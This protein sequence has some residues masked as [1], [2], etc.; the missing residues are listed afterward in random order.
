MGTTL[1]TDIYDIVNSIEEVKSEY[2]DESEET[3]SVGIYGWLG[4]VEARKI[5]SSIIV[6]SEMGNELFPQKAKYMQNL[7]SHAINYNIENINAVPATMTVLLG[8]HADDIEN[9]IDVSTNTFVIDRESVLSIEGYEFHTIY[10]IVIKKATVN[11]TTVY[12]AQYNIEYG[13]PNITLSSPYLPSPYNMVINNET[14]VFI[15]CQITQMTYATNYNHII[16]N[17]LI[18]N[19]I[20]TFTFENQLSYFEVFVT[21]SDGETTFI[22]PIFEGSAVPT[23]VGLYCYYTYIDTNTIRV[24]FTR[25]SYVPT[26]NDDIEIK[27]YTTLGESGNFKYSVDSYGVLES[28]NYNYTNIDYMIRPLTDSVNGTDRKSKEELRRILPKE[29]L[30]RGIISTT[31]DLDNYFNMI[32]TSSNRIKAQKKVDNQTERTF[33][34]YMVMKDSNDD[35]VPTNTLALDIDLSSLKIQELQEDERLLLPAGTVFGYDSVSGRAYV[36]DTKSSSTTATISTDVDEDDEEVDDDSDYDIVNSDY[37]NLND[38][39]NFVYI[40]PFH[41]IINKSPLY[42][43]YMLT[44]IHINPYLAFTFINLNSIVSF[45]GSTISWERLFYTDNKIYNMSIDIAQNINKDLGLVTLISLI[46]ED[47]QVDEED[48]DENL[49]TNALNNNYYNKSKDYESCYGSYALSESSID[50]NTT[51]ANKQIGKSYGTLKEAIDAGSYTVSSSYWVYTVINNY[52]VKIG[53]VSISVD[54]DGNLS[55]Y[56]FRHNITESDFLNTILSSYYITTQN[57]N[58]VCNI[59]KT[60]LKIYKSLNEAVNSSIT[61]DGTYY[62][63]TKLSTGD[64]FNIGSISVT[65][66]DDYKSFRWLSSITTHT[67][68]TYDSYGKFTI[69]SSNYNVWDYSSDNITWH[70]TIQKAI[71]DKQLTNG[72][73]YYVYFNDKNNHP[74]RLGQLYVSTANTDTLY[75]ASYSFVSLDDVSI[76]MYDNYF[77]SYILSS[78]K[79]KDLELD[80]ANYNSSLFDAIYANEKESGSYYVYTMGSKGFACLIGELTISVDKTISSEYACNYVWDSLE[81]YEV[82]NDMRVVA[83]FYRD[84]VPY[85]YEQLY[86][87]INESDVESYSY[88]FETHLTTDDLLDLD[89]NIKIL[90]SYVAKYSDRGYGYFNPNTKCD[91]YVF[92][93]V[94]D[95]DGNYIQYPHTGGSVSYY[96]GVAVKEYFPAIDLDNCTLTNIYSVDGGVDFYTNYGNVMNSVVTPIESTD[97]PGVTGSYR[98]SGVPMIGYRYSMD[99]D[100]ITEVVDAMN[101][102]KAYMDSCLAYL[103]NTIGIDFKFF[104]TFGPSHMYTIDG[105]SEY[106]DRVNVSLIFALK[107]LN[108]SDTDTKTYIEQDVKAYI[109]DLDE[110]DSVHISKLITQINSDYENSISYFDFLGFN[111]YDLT[112]LHIYK[113]DES[114]AEIDIPPEFINVNNVWND[115]TQAYEPDITI[116][117]IE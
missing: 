9:N 40:S 22:T 84:G 15:N 106:I 95:D 72:N 19:K 44:K 77:T 58:C 11:N 49:I 39:S 36:Y 54:T 21:D 94:K 13:D 81:E 111:N 55:S 80:S 89:N 100:H 104:N 113:D 85:R 66:A 51:V 12:T 25:S 7:I 63:Y 78:T 37:G 76:N 10:D 27:I 73:D 98:I 112:V 101:I 108:S 117:L 64:L 50:I 105:E 29:A 18:E 70:D 8:I 83:L 45:I 26:L 88:N 33:Y 20:V 67:I 116:K 103:E 109:E 69:L 59:D 32:N 28:S 4:S 107:L 53:N 34:T 87:N 3:L 31:A 16:T 91:I 75:C 46:K 52:P 6:A 74:I 17:N 82:F 115:T 42:M 48:V 71:L 14:Y 23:G 110:I 60:D 56:S 93:K 35:I 65:I 62:V 24:K 43:Q 2:I 102:R 97:D 30:A 38:P 90:D 114:E 96:P 57:G 61:E 92:A 99:E 86:L 1:T 47:D 79:L 41:I 5:Q 68:K